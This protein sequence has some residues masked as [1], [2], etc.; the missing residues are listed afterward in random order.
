MLHRIAL[1]S[2]VVPELGP[3]ATIAAAAAGGFDAVGLWVE[4][5]QWS[6][7]TVTEVRRG[8]RDSGLDLIDVEVIW[9]KPGPLDPAHRRIL[10]IGLELGAANALVVSS[11]PDL[12]ATMEK[13]EQLCEHV[14]RA[15]LRVSLE[16]GLFT[17][18]KDIG[19]ASAIV[20]AV[21]HSNAALLVD[22]LH[23]DRSGG[24]VA[25]VAAL[26][27][28][29]LSYVQLCDAPTQRPRRA[30]AAGILQ[31]AVYGRLQ[32]GEGGLPLS[33]LI[34][35]LPPGLP[36]S[37]ELRSQALYDAYPDAAARAR[38]TALATRAFLAKRA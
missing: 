25:D 30:D 29:W 18:V 1:A 20:S 32:A 15:P 8:L 4:P 38:V 3:V 2:G 17:E 35:V 28:R 26:P 23:L 34:S 36:I 19:T 5:D 13:F 11:D 24:T 22:A 33:A 16:F 6:A 14:A 21:D 12:C 37:V 31:E 10:D 7:G 9:I 27:A